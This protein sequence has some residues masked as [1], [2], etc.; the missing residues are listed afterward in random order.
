MSLCAL[1]CDDLLGYT[2]LSAQQWQNWFA[3][4][5]SALEVPCDI[6]QTGTVRHF[7][8]H[9]FAVELRFAERLLGEDI[10]AYEQLAIAT[11]G[12]LFAIHTRATE[13]YAQYLSTATEAAMDEV[14][15]VQTRSA[16]DFRLSRRSIFVH[17]LLHSARHWAQLATLVRQAGFPEVDGQDYFLYA[18]RKS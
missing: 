15:E 4:N 9:I 3:A 13:K 17:A 10:T 1:S 8:Q 16:G 11:T 12:E 7:V 2:N 6:R 14:L 18:S 5:E